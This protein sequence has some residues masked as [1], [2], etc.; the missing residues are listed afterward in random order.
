MTLP[1][2]IDW[3]QILLHA[4]NLVLLTGG[5]YILVFKPVKHF[6]DQRTQ[7]YQDMQKDAAEKQAQAEQMRSDYELRL[8]QADSEIQQRRQSALDQAEQEASALLDSARSQASKL[9]SE[10]REN[11]AREEQQIV[12]SAQDEITRL[13]VEATHK[14]MDCPLSQVYDQFLDGAEGSGQHE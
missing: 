11:A 3:Q 7:A 12:K 13:S 14:L 2:N 4:L 10:A 9:L 6:M 1:L 5:L 8:Q